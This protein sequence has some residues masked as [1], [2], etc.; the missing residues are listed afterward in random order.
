M[1][2]HLKIL[3]QLELAFDEPP[4]PA[5]SATYSK[6]RGDAILNTAISQIP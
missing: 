2:L 6:L 1:A 4:L 5:K 3:R